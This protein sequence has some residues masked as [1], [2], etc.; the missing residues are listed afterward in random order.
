MKTVRVAL[1][2][3][4]AG[5]TTNTFAQADRRPQLRAGVLAGSVVIDGVLEEAVWQDVEVADAFT[6]VEPAEGTGVGAATRLRVLA[7]T[8]AIVIGIELATSGSFV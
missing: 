8:K 4:L 7:G 5:A 6:Q 1:V 3:V 2:F